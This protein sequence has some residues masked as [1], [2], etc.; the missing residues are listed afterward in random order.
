MDEFQE[1][2]NW[3][4]KIKNKVASYK[5]FKYIQHLKICIL[6]INKYDVKLRKTS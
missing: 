5:K 4:E 6:T 2:K 3:M 1:N